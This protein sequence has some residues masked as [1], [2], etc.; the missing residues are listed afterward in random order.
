MGKTNNWCYH[1]TWYTNNHQMVLIEGIEKRI[2]ELLMKLCAES[3]MYLSKIEVTPDSVQMILEAEEQINTSKILRNIQKALSNVLYKEFPNLKSVGAELWDEDYLMSTLNDEVAEGDVRIEKILNALWAVEYYDIDESITSY[4]DKSFEKDIDKFKNYLE[5]RKLGIVEYGDRMILVDKEA[6]V[7][8][9]NLN[10]FECTKIYKYGCCCGSPCDMSSKNKKMFDKY[11]LRIENEVKNLDESQYQ[12]IVANGGFWAADGSLN[13]WNGH[14][15]LLIEH[16]GVR[17]CIAH[18]YALDY[19]IPIY[20]LCPLSCL[21]YPLEIIELITNKQKTIILLTSVLDEA[22]AEEFGRWGSYKS[23][24]VDL[25]CIDKKAHNEVFKEKDY[26]SVY[27]V[28]ENLLIHE[29]GD[30]VYKGIAQLF[31]ENTY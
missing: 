22:F 26:K 4:I 28:N 9:I 15:A 14:C 21:M 1:I 5:G 10:C 25:R 19:H 29:F 6:L 23:L 20:E 18:K 16:E 30:K 11:S 2:I 3:K 31:D 13:E 7:K 17:K 24:D 27:K 12:E 8:E